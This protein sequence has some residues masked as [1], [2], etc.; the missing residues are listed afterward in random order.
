MHGGQPEHTNTVLQCTQPRSP[1]PV[2]LRPPL[3]HFTLHR[4]HM[5]ERSV[6]NPFTP[7][8]QGYHP[9]PP[10][11][12]FELLLPL[13]SSLF[14]SLSSLSRSLSFF[15]LMWYVILVT[16]HFSCYLWRPFF[17]LS[18]FLI[19][20]VY[21]LNPRPFALLS[22]LFYPFL[23]RFILSSSPPLS[24]AIFFITTWFQ[25]VT[26]F[27]SPTQP[28]RPLTYPYTPPAPS[29]FFL[30]VCLAWRRESECAFITL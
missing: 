14:F 28:P 4:S 25:P 5:E 30:K 26:P 29:S 7:A 23:S 18:S 19:Y 2:V 6:N 3:S 17:I 27:L 22:L 15:F 24:H 9:P 13:I 11:L 16:A 12:P 10:I 1:S 20:F 21:P 8:K